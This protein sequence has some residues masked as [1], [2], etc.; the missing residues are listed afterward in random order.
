MAPTALSFVISI[1]VIMSGGIVRRD[2]SLLGI[3]PK[4]L[5]RTLF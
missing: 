1:I 5:L 2:T 4:I 3:L